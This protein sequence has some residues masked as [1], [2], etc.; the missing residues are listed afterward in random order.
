MLR[1]NMIAMTTNLVCTDA[2]F[3]Q[4]F[5]DR[6]SIHADLRLS[7]DRNDPRWRRYYAIDHA[8]KTYIGANRMGR[9]H[10]PWDF[11]A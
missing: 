5:Y 7:D 1:Y 3:D 11:D 9:E 8:I 10:G 4:L 2:N 6:D